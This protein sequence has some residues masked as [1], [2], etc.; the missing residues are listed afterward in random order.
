MLAVSSAI[1]FVIRSNCIASAIP[2]FLSLSS[3]PSKSLVRFHAQGPRSSSSCSRGP[4][5]APPTKTAVE[6]ARSGRSSCKKCSSAIA[7]DALRVGAVS[8]D[9]RGFDMTKWHH[10]GCFPFSSLDSVE[11]IGGFSSLKVWRVN[12][13]FRAFPLFRISVDFTVATLHFIEFTR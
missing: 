1:P 8:R 2:R 7:K 6:Y 4:A 10:L 11:A 13:K 12:L 5:M 3:S 9:S